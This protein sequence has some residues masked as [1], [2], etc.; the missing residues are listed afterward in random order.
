MILIGVANYA[1]EQIILSRIE[2]LAQ[3]ENGKSKGQTLTFEIADFD[4]TLYHITF[5]P[6]P[7]SVEIGVSLKFFS[8]LSKYDAEKFLREQYGDKLKMEKDRVSTQFELAG[9]SSDLERLSH[10]AA[11]LKRNCFGAIFN[12]FFE[13]QAS[14]QAEKNPSPRAIIPFR[15]DETMYIQATSDRVTVIYS[16]IFKDPDDVIIGKIF[17]QELTEARRRLD[18]SP[19]VLYSHR[20]PP[21][22]LQNTPAATG[23]NVAFITFVLYPRHFS[24]TSRRKT[25]DLMHTLRT[26]LHY[27]IKCAKAY[28]QMRMRAKTADFIKVLNRALPT[29]SATALIR[30]NPMGDVLNESKVMRI[31]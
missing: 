31:S 16:T 5:S 8:E 23:D 28:M 20:D 9:P 11:L 17:M 29:N 14:G 22:E 19:Q 12:W 3:D 2:M 4:G 13:Y 1:V 10:N 24:N 30:I 27:H 6:D 26:Y 18:R 15:E 21:A 7:A 25:I